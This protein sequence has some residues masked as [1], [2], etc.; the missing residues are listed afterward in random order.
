[1][2]ERSGRQWQYPNDV[3]RYGLGLVFDSEELG[4]LLRLVH[5]P[6]EHLGMVLLG[7][8]L[9]QLHQD[10]NRQP[11]SCELIRDDREPRDETSHFRSPECRGLR[12]PQLANA[13]IE[14]RRISELAVELPS[15]E[16]GQLDDKSD[17]EMP[18]APNQVCEA[19]VDITRGGRFHNNQLTR[20]SSPPV[21][22]EGAP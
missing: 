7:Q 20:V 19:A 11:A 5:G 21:R 18:L 12:K 6:G 13:V 14:E 17:Y 4:F 9:S 16:A 22:A 10:P 8:D 1:E 2:R 15:R 3:S